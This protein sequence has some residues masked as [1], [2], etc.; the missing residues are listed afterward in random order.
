MMD[1]LAQVVVWLNAVANALGRVVLAPVSA[2]P[3]WLSA[4]L[5]AAGTGLLLLVVFKYTS[6]Q[7][8][9][10]AVRNDVK[11]H[12]LALRLFKDSPSVTLRAQG[13]ILAGAVRLLALAIVPMLVMLVPVALILGQLSLWYQVRPLR[14]GE[15]AVVTVALS[16]AGSSW[17]E[18]CLEPTGAVEV[19]LGPVR[20][21]SK[22]ELCWNLRGRRRGQHRLVF[23]VNGQ[24]VAKELAVGDGFLRV[25]TRRP[26]WDWSE[27]LLHPAEEPLGPES[28]VRSIAIDYP[29]RASWTSGTDAW[30]IY[31]FAVSM[32]A[33][34]A[35][36]RVLNVN[37]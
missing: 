6:N 29:R 20:V 31:W 25:S 24:A 3:G 19:T 36:R 35:F 13:R 37:L 5:A 14:V 22:R 33:A 2:L 21:L 16:D 12:L 11:A 10:K 7:R 1:A 17:P 34:L 23:H 28:P 8:A 15:D 9:L 4:T 18:V 32:V 26:G 27:A 30:V